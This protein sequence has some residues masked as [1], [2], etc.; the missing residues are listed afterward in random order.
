MVGPLIDSQIDNIVID[1]KQTTN[2]TVGSTKTEISNKHLHNRTEEIL[3]IW[4]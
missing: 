4:K 2:Q 1:F 3:Q